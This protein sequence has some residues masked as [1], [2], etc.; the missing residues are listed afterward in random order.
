MKATG[1]VRR[2]D[3][4]GRIAIP[5]HIRTDLNI[6]EGDPFEVFIETSNNGICFVP[7]HK[8]ASDEIERIA[9]NLDVVQY[10]EDIIKKLKDIAKEMKEE[11]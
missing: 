4:L 9:D 1:I 3:H 11:E 8:E 5:L 7:Y 6:K 2:I 10:G